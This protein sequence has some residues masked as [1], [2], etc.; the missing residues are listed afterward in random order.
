MSCHSQTTKKRTRKVKSPHL[1]W[2]KFKDNL[3]ELFWIGDDDRPNHT[4]LYYI[5]E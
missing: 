4:A 1:T 5:Q 2:I 3:I